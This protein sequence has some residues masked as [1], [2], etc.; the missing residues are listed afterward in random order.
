MKSKILNRIKLSRIYETFRKLRFLLHLTPSW[1]KFKDFFKH[2]FIGL[3]DRLDRHHIFLLS[4]GL[5]FSLFVCIIPLTLII[6]WILG[7]FL[8][9][10]EM[11]VQIVTLIQTV[12]PYERYAEFVKEII[13]ARVHEVIEYRNIAGYIGIIG[14]FFAASSFASSLRTVLK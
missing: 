10:A 6:F 2:Y 3:Y 4:G 13:F 7:K 8:D 11:E 5:A 1:H 9:S 12:I 14:L